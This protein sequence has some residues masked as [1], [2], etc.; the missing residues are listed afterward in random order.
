MCPRGRRKEEPGSLG[1]PELQDPGVWFSLHPRQAL[2][3]GGHAEDCGAALACGPVCLV[4]RMQTALP[5][6]PVRSQEMA[7]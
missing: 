4:E 5:P 1:F 7:W 2:G 6:T 3:A